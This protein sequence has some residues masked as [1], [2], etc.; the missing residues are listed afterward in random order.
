MQVKVGSA[1]MLELP[2]LRQGLKRGTQ[3]ELELGC[4]MAAN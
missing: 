2:V 1:G 3:E 4:H